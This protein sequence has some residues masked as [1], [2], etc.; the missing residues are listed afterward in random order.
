MKQA[1]VYLVDDEETHLLALTKMI[2]K[3][4][5]EAWSYTR[6][7]QFFEDADKFKEGSVVILD[8]CMPEMDGIETMVRLGKMENP[9]AVILVS[10]HDTELLL[11]AEKLG[12][13]L[14]LEILGS[15]TKP[16]LG[17]QLNELL[18]GRVA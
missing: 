8:L 16:V 18:E 7:S 12:R 3:M 14:K 5:I 17:R 6:A 11:S 13:G 2:E 15:L 4:G 10:G 1:A 9:P